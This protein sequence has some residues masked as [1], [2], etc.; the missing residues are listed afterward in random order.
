MSTVID[1][2]TPAN[3]AAEPQSARP[4]AATRAGSPLGAELS[5]LRHRR[6]VVALVALGLLGLLV[7]LAAVTFTHD[8]DLAAAQ[9]RAQTEFT[10]QVRDQATSIAQCRADPT[11]SAAQKDVVCGQADPTLTAAAFYQDPRLRADQ[12]LPGLAIGV[13]VAGALLMSLVAAT[14]VGADWSSRAIITLLTWQPRRLRFLATRL[15]AIAIAAAVVGAVAQALA[16][17]L[18][19]LAVAT[20]GTF[21]ATPP[22]SDG[23]HYSDPGQALIG[24]THFWRDLLSLQGRAVL[25]MVLAALI[26]AGVAMV[27]RSTGGFLGVA[28]GWLVVVEVAGQGLLL[29]HVPGLAR[30]T[31]TQNVAALLSPGG[32][33][34]Y[35]GERVVN[36]QQVVQS[37]HLSN[38]A[39]LWHLGLLAVVTTAAAGALLRRR[40]L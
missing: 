3:P 12:G 29:Q 26:A 34:V 24:A 31:L 5:R 23:V 15:G 1:D 4:R 19:A 17:G 14:A 40:D 25:L 33:T 27:T 16:L 35:L 39:G 10:Q 11:V 6:L 13:G 28:L 21:A 36:G 37:V 2:P 8:R 9:V 30:W 18:G 22:P 20:R 32:T 38:L 7:A